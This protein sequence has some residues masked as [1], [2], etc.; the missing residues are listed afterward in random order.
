[1]LGKDEG[2]GSVAFV[3]GRRI[4]LLPRPF[5]DVGAGLFLCVGGGGVGLLGVV[6]ALS[7]LYKSLLGVLAESKD[8]EML[9]NALGIVFVGVTIGTLPV[10]LTGG[11]NFFWVAF[12]SI[13]LLVGFCVTFGIFS[14]V[15]V[16]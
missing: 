15:V 16:E 12:F 4:V 13:G 7:E 6:G 9:E 8:D 11:W 14:C 2:P 10:A 1:M 5:L 3:A